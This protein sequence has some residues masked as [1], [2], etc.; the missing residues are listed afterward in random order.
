VKLHFVTEHGNPS[1]HKNIFSSDIDTVLKT[2]V[3]WAVAV[4]FFV[5]KEASFNSKFSLLNLLATA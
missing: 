1:N 3:S 5:P 2:E 4:N